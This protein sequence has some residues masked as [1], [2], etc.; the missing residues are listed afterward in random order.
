[1]LNS[2]SSPLKR[3]LHLVPDLN[4]GGVESVLEILAETKTKGAW[5]NIFVATRTG[6]SAANRIRSQGHNVIVLKK[7][8]RIPDIVLLIKLV[9]LLQKIR[10]DLVHCRCVEANFHGVIAARFAGGIPVLLEEVGLT[11]DQR[12]RLAKRIL[13]VIYSFAKAIICPSRAIF[14]DLKD[15]G[16]RHPRMVVLPNP[17]DPLFLAKPIRQPN[18]ICFT[19]VSRLVP[20]KNLPLLLRAFAR[21]TSPRPVVLEVFGAGPLLKKLKILSRKLGIYSRVRWHGFCKRSPKNFS[22][23]SIYVLTSEREGHPVALLE[24]L[25]AGLPV[26]AT[27]VGGVKEI[28]GSRSR[29]GV[30][31]PSHDEAALASAFN[32]IIR[33]G[34]GARLE[35][36]SE[37]RKIVQSRFAPDKYLQRLHRIYD[38]CTTPRG[39]YS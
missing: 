18:R 38:F 22:N 5:Q 7:A 24:A 36:G 10:P 32:K 35:M 2:K 14:Q 28:I 30:L 37:A 31:V 8:S 23:S 4:F 39:F 9:M 21:I 1:M 17:V 33:I 13:K 27:S 11:S 29:A 19:A 3:V 16:I 34:K 15:A 6:G 12:S 25:A 20:E 26:V